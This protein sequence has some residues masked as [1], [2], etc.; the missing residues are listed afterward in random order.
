MLRKATPKAWGSREVQFLSAARQQQNQTGG[1]VK[2]KLA[3][4]GGEVINSKEDLIVYINQAG[5]YIEQQYNLPLSQ[6]SDDDIYTFDHAENNWIT[7]DPKRRMWFNGSNFICEMQAF[8]DK[9][10]RENGTGVVARWSENYAPA[11]AVSA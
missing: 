5:I 7:F 3:N 6:Q 9:H 8:Q 2:M 4:G 11:K 10:H 1:T